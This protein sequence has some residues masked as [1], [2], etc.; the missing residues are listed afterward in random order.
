MRSFAHM[1]S[2]ADLQVEVVEVGAGA[3][4]HVSPRAAPV[5]ALQG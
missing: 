5:R 1:S 3:Q 4:V 2:Q